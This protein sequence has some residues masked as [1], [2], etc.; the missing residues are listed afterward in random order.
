MSFYPGTV[1]MPA[2]HMEFQLKGDPQIVVKD[3]FK[4]M[5]GVTVLNSISLNVRQGEIVSLCGPSGSGKTTLL[6]IIAGFELPDRGEIIIDGVEVSSPEHAVHPSMRN[7]SM[8]FQ[9]LALWPHMTV[10][11]HLEFAI[12]RDD[13]Q[14]TGE[15][16][17]KTIDY[18]LDFVKMK[19]MERRLPGELSGGE[20]QRL[21][22]ARAFISNPAYLLMDEPFS[23]LDPG[24][25]KD[26]W[27]IVMQLRGE[28]TGILHVS[29]DL[30]ESRRFSDR[31]LF[32]EN[33]QVRPFRD[34]S[35]EI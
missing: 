11:Q 18:W 14:G 1:F 22:L 19:G 34:G 7:C 25:R 32:M 15:A 20:C 2:S 35:G 8:I 16:R 31:M 12:K 17:A 13:T 9:N 4:E 30:E 3:I 29:H 23:N 6:R 28:S 26:M 33:G 27:D 21:A 24:L 10:R 5:G